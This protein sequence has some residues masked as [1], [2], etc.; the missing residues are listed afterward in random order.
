MSDEDTL[1][2]LLVEDNPGDVRLIEELLD[3]ATRRAATLSDSDSVGTPRLRRTARLAD[4]LQQLEASRV[5]VL[6][7]DLGLPDSS[8][9]D[10]LETVRDRTNEVPVVVLTGLHDE[11]V[12][13]QAVQ[14]GAQEY[15]V[16][17]ELTPPL[18]YRSIRHAIERKKFDR[19]QAALHDASRDLVQ[20]ESKAE[21]SQFAVDAAADVFEHCCIGIFLFDAETNALEPTAVYTDHFEMDSGDVPTLHPNEATITW[22]AFVD[23][24][25]IVCED[26]QEIDYFRRLDVPLRSGLWVPLD[27]HG[28]LV[29]VSEE[30]GGIDQQTQQLADHLAATAEVALDRVEREESLRRQ[31]RELAT[32]NRQLEELNRTNDLIRE[33][34]QVLV[35]ATTRD[36]IEQAVC[37]LL[38]RTE[39][40]AF[41]WI[42]EVADG[43]ITPRSWAGAGPDYLDIV[44]LSVSDSASPAATTASTGATTVVSNVA[45]GLR[46]EPWRKAA[47]ARGLQSAISIPLQYNELPYGVLTVFATEPDAFSDRSRRV[48]EQ[49][50]ETIAY[51]MNSVE[52]RRTLLTDTVV[53]LELEIRETGGQFEQLAREAGCHLRYGGLVPQTDGTTRIFFDATDASSDVVVDAAATIPGIRDIDYIGSGDDA[54]RLRFEAVISGPTVPSVLVECGGIARSIR[55]EDAV[56]HVVVELPDATDVRS[57][58][59]RVEEK[60]PETKLRARRDKERTDRPRQAF[61]TT[62]EAELTRRQLEVLQTAYH[63]G[64]FEWPRDRTGEE[65]ATALGITQPTFNAHLRTAERKL[66]AMLFDD[67]PVSSE[68]VNQHT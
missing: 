47:I 21:V 29:I 43:E 53:E 54:G 41:A 63:S 45:S 65:V 50:G 34:D 23:D 4:G 68:R 66:C 16:K 24:E 39:R 33:I 2:V 61:G 35:Q 15:L 6:L 67:G 37:E 46:D 59:N 56:T 62:L 3:E 51:A 31:E 5:D 57:F 36:A 40:F 55:V 7:L 8:G 17:D 44:S 22:Q 38:T 18:L 58:V 64:Y 1:E 11:S 10:T 20:A 13:V 25:T 49:L 52:T 42:G 60:Y 32:Q 9:I 19:T 30:A 26:L 27:G 12:G 28:V 48:F 14:R